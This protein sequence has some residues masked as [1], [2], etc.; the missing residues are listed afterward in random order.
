M[1]DGLQARI[2][3]LDGVRGIAILLVIAF[4][5]R[6]VFAST[7]EMPLPV[8]RVLGLGWS[9][10]DLF[11]ALSGFLITGILLD[12]RKSPHYFR[13]FYLRRAL[14][15]FPLYFGYLF[16]VLVV[17]R[18][19]WLLISGN[20]LWR[21]TDA[22]WYF[23][24]LL[25]W[26][27]DHG[28]NDLY[29][30]HLWSL[31]IEEQFY[32]VWPAVV[33]LVPRRQLKWVCVAVAAGAPAAR[34]YLAAHGFDSEAIYRMTPCRMDV[35]AMGAFVA[36]GLRDFRETLARWKPRVL[37]AAGGGI[38]AIFAISPG[39]VW[40]NAPMRVAGASLIGLLYA[41]LVHWAATTDRGRL[42]TICCKPFLRL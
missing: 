14:R 4:H 27:L 25:N 29:L 20:D 26:K 23:S 17:T 19:G 21:S 40:S 1:P 38:L 37:A 2:P 31:A 10:V 13:A 24:Y 9:G 28:Y 15:I 6:A 42:R 35:L 22:R 41:G 18:Y 32:V 3:A 7:L 39:P 5:A 30:G 16:L 34:V 36:I 11:F 12:S 33:F 8:F